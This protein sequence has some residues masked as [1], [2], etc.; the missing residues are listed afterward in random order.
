[1][2]MAIE[3]SGWQLREFL[4]MAREVGMESTE[5]LWS[6]KRQDTDTSGIHAKVSA[7]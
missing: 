6:E 2:G 5:S 1:M 3:F 4:G 7:Q